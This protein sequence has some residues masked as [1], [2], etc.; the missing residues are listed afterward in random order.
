MAGRI[1]QPFIDEVVAR[2]D[3]VEVI[4]ARVPLAN[5]FG[6][7]TR[8]RSITQGR[9]NYTMQFAVYEPVPQAIYE[10]LTA[11]TSGDAE[12]RARA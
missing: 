3:I 4:S 9:A 5:M 12:A 1:P 7:A 6:Y 10:E 8:L 2:S 11:R